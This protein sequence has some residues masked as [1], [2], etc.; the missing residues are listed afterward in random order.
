M[1]I[2]VANLTPEAHKALVECLKIAARRGRILREARE[3]E[4][5]ALRAGSPQIS[6]VDATHQRASSDE[7]S[8]HADSRQPSP[9]IP[10]S[11]T[12]ASE[13]ATT[14]TKASSA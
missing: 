6:T 12:T 5:A 8:I 1:Q 3:R 2:D 7:Q 10:C 4:Q 9:S 14:G 11:D 13:L